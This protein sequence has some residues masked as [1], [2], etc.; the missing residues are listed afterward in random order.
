MAKA[1]IS[2]ESLQ[3]ERD[4]IIR[5]R[6]QS[7]LQIHLE[8][9]AA[10]EENNALKTSYETNK[11]NYEAMRERFEVGKNSSIDLFRAMTDFNMAEFR[12]IT[13]KYNLKLKEELLKLRL[14]Y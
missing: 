14:E 3:F 10:L 5:D 2:T 9:E 8:Y 11:M 12:L 13:S 7:L 4:K 1:R 6:Q